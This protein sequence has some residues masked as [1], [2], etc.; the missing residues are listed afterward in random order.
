MKKKQKKK[1]KKKKV[2][3]QQLNNGTKVAK[4]KRDDAGPSKVEEIRATVGER[5]ARWLQDKRL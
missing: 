3:W 2:E 5:E 4:G 1:K